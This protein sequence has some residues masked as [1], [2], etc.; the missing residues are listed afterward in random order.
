MEWATR[1]ASWIDSNWTDHI[2]YVCEYLRRTLSLSAFE[3][4]VPLSLIISP[5]EQAVINKAQ[6]ETLIAL[7]GIYPMGPKEIKQYVDDN[8]TNL[9]LPEIPDSPP[10]NP[11]TPDPNATSPTDPSPQTDSIEDFANVNS[12]VVDDVMRRV[13]AWM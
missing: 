8:F 6:A 5:D 13:A 2:E 7:S 1:L 10:V 3:I 11:N 4:D 12:A 9:S